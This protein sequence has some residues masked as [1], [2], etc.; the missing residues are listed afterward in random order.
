MKKKNVYN[1]VVLYTQMNLETANK[2]PAKLFSIDPVK[3]KVE[4]FIYG[5]PALTAA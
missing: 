5:Q 3:N 4:G 2:F 1:N